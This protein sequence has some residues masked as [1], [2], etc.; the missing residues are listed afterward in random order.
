M[1][2]YA[3]PDSWLDMLDLF[4]SLIVIINFDNKYHSVA[5]SLRDLPKVRN[6]VRNAVWTVSLSCFLNVILFQRNYHRYLN[7]F[8]YILRMVY[9]VS[10]N[11]SIF[12]YVITYILVLQVLKPQRL[13][14]CLFKVIST[15]KLVFNLHIC[16]SF[17]FLFLFLFLLFLPN[18]SS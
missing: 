13:Y 11:S 1:T 12:Q 9:K 2:P 18:L 15:S 16:Y 4:F 5:Q 6:L 14:R 10:I 3:I 7:H 8:L 17:L